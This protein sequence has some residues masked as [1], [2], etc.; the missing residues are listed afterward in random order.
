MHIVYYTWGKIAMCNLKK[1]RYF[2][3]DQEIMLFRE[4]QSCPLFIRQHPERGTTL[5]KRSETL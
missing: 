5:Q 1:P 4:T 2:L 3:P